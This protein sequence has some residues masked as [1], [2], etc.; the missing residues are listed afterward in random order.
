MEEHEIA[1][2]E[3]PARA[4]SRAAARQAVILVHGM[5]EQIPM[6]T[7]KSFVSTLA[8]G[9]GAPGHAEIW[10]K[11]DARTGSLE[12]RRLTTRKSRSG[13]AFPNGVRSD[14]YELYWAD[15]TAGSTSGQLVGWIRY[16][17]LRPW[18]RVPGPVR[19][20]WILLWF[21]VVLAVCLI[22][23]GFI[24]ADAWKAVFPGWLPQAT[25]IAAAAMIGGL[26]QQIGTRSFGRVVKYTRAE[27][28]NIAARAA[29]RDRGLKLIR[30]LH[31]NSEYDRVIVVGHS[32]GS[33]LAFDLVS[34]FWAEQEEARTVAEGDVSFG[35]LCDLER[36]AQPLW[37][38]SPSPDD[39]SRYW[40]AQSA[41]RRSLDKKV[42]NASAR[43]LISDLVT[44]GSP[45]THAEFLL[46]SSRQDLKKRQADRELP[47][48]PPMVEE[49]D[50]WRV[51]YARKIGLLPE[52]RTTLMA[53][54]SRDPKNSWTI[55]HGAV[56]SAVRWTNIYDPARLILCGDLIS[57][58]M[59]LSFGNGVCDV[60][61]ADIDG[62]SSSFTHT[63]YWSM[64][65]SSKRRKCFVDVMNMV[66]L[67]S[68][69]R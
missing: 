67:D 57:G 46:A 33:I 32:L 27:P 43:W 29:V 62:Q 20:A 4:E 26:A 35:N 38:G 50:E 17:L 52:G 8:D 25:A 15:L 2:E 55:H 56:F 9:D 18:S 51:D 65:Q 48:C 68:P 1:A 39:H 31:Q 6:D 34:Y 63:K 49:L 59:R 28:D 3:A 30:A 16:L 11:P 66:D 21:L 22:A 54:P 64:A 13:G 7:I 5:G 14:F 44:F 58:P 40:K 69:P 45:L 12:L 42:S 53:F 24:P 10:S 61:L 19:G 41:L 60:S 36:A 23:I 37:N 47:R